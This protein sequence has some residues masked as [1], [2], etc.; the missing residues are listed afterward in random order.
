MTVSVVLLTWALGTFLLD[1][2]SKISRGAF[3]KVYN[4]EQD[5]PVSGSAQPAMLHYGCFA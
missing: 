5:F 4:C 1:D 2:A 3:H